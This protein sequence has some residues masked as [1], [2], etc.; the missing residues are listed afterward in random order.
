MGTSYHL[1]ASGVSFSTKRALVLLAVG[2]FLPSFAMFSRSPEYFP[3]I[4]VFVV[5]PVWWMYLLW[6]G[7]HMTSFGIS[8]NILLLLSGNPTVYLAAFYFLAWLVL[9]VSLW[10]LRKRGT[11]TRIVE[12][13]IVLNVAPALFWGWLLASQL[14]QYGMLGLGYPLPF[15][16]LPF[17]GLYVLRRWKVRLPSVMSGEIECPFCRNRYA[18]EPEGVRAGKMVRCPRCGKTLKV[19]G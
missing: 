12:G 11:R 8:S 15:P 5:A 17:M 6:Y 14:F 18:T 13:A 16:I 2:M 9:V 7:D 19:T 1:D 4:Q 3:H 10:V